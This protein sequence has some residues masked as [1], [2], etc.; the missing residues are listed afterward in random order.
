MSFISS[1][2]SVEQI[3][4]QCTPLGNLLPFSQPLGI[5]FRAFLV[6]HFVLRCIERY[7]VIKNHTAEFAAGVFINITAG[8]RPW[9]KKGSQIIVVVKTLLR[10][11]DD[12]KRIVKIYGQLVDTWRETYP[13]PIVFLR[14]KGSLDAASV[15]QAPH[16][17]SIIADF[18]DPLFKLA[19]RVEAYA[20]ISLKLLDEI[21]INL[22]RN[23][24][25]LYEAIIF[26]RFTEFENIT[27]VGVNLSEI[28]ERLT[29]DPKKL[30]LEIKEHQDMVD[31]LL[32]TIGSEYTVDQICHLV[33]Q[34]TSLKRKAGRIAR[35]GAQTAQE[36]AMT[37][38]FM[39]TGQAPLPATPAVLR[40][41]QP[42]HVIRSFD[43]DD[44]CTYSP[45]K[46]R[47]WDVRERFYTSD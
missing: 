39:A 26:D 5:A 21:F 16:L 42:N 47:R 27:G 28:F 19:L 46:T 9:V 44:C 30:S 2:L 17:I 41:K 31:R 23:V 13:L 10:I 32:N 8:D 29:P 15:E 1:I 43:D 7:D 25:V 36:V 37:V 14:A 18:P 11:F 6:G 12:Q 40:P 38:S 4:S 35:E 45:R 34:S 24:L 22:A 33:E 20:T 3:A